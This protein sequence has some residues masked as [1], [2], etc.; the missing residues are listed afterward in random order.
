MQQ[1][2]IE[3][4]KTFRDAFKGRQDT[5]PR[6]WISKDGTQQGYSPLCKNEWKKGICNKPCRTCENADY[7]PLSDQLV[8]DHFKGKHVLGVYPLLVDNTCNFIV[9]DFDNHDNSR[10]PLE[11]VKAY[12]E[13]CQVQDIPCYILKSKSGKGYHIY[14]YFKRPVPAWKARAVFFA[15]LQESSVIDDDV[16]PASFD[17]LFP[18]QDELS[19]K[20]F[21][22][23]IALP[24]QGRVAK[25]GHTLFLDP[26]TGFTKPYEDQWG[27]L[28]SI[29][30]VNEATLDEII[31]SWNLKREKAYMTSYSGLNGNKEVV[32]R[33]LKCQFVQ[34]CKEHAAELHEPLWHSLISNL[35]SV[36]PGG[37]TLC[38]KYSLRYPKYSR[39]ETDQKIL[40]ALDGSGP[41]TCEYIRS[42]GFKC[43]KECNVKSPAGLLF[44]GNLK[45]GDPN[46][47]RISISFKGS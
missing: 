30:R 25:E 3:K 34:H 9:G 20:G 1:I 45:N 35:I 28:S 21:G 37:V 6:Y 16:K 13:T 12:H 29:K 43:D 5:V 27:V 22:N 4:V 38:H 46:V 18:N 26:E 17:R 15:L 41:H 42:S 33:L 19:G 31:E 24:F 32:E 10:N 11:D 44:N 8:L 2:E 47:K 7:I 23:L 40:H 36:R 14:I 39:S